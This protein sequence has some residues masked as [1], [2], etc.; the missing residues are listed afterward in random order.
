[1][2]HCVSEDEYRGTYLDNRLFL[3]L[4]HVLSLFLISIARDHPD[5]PVKRPSQN[6]RENLR[7][8]QTTIFA[9]EDNDCLRLVAEGSFEGPAGD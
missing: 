4:R 7:T 5:T 8:M 1:M 9:L 3:F 2:Y 6:I